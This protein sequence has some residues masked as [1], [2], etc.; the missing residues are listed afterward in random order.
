MAEKVT[1][2]GRPSR[3]HLKERAYRSQPLTAEPEGI[4]F[5]FL[6]PT[7]DR[8]I[9]NTTGRVAPSTRPSGCTHPARTANSRKGS[10]RPNRTRR[11]ASANSLPT[12]KRRWPAGAASTHFSLLGQTSRRTIGSPVGLQRT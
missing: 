1:R 10:I 5:R 12:S 6:R 7:D 2:R 11:L 8:G 4:Q 3:E 9:S